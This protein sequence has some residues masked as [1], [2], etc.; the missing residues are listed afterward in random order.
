MGSSS[1]NTKILDFQKKYT[2]VLDPKIV[3]KNIAQGEMSKTFYR[4]NSS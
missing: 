1:S 3:G 4:E 2:Q